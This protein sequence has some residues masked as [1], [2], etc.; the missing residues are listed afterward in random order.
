MRFSSFLAESHGAD[1]PSKKLWK[2]RK[3]NRGV[4]ISKAAVWEQSQRL[5]GKRNSYVL[6][7]W[8]QTAS[9][10]RAEA[11][12]VTLKPFPSVPPPRW[13]EPPQR[14]SGCLISKS[15]SAHRGARNKASSSS[16][17]QKLLCSD[18]PHEKFIISHWGDFH[19]DGTPGTIKQN[20]ENT[21]PLPVHR[22]LL[23]LGAVDAA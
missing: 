7:S 10:I 16:A 5:P 19:S 21:S 12:G 18:Y 14:L 2:G 4:G 8:K 22:C 13:L 1:C 20:Y 6:V 23:G 3:H 9:S 15:Q 17:D 11:A